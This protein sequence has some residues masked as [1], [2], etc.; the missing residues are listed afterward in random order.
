MS[1]QVP[2]EKSSCRRKRRREA[3]SP[4]TVTRRYPPRLSCLHDEF[5][6]RPLYLIKM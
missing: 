6:I 1:Y 3:A 2:R 4:A 5:G